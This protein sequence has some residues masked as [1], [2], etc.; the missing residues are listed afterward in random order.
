MPL[1]QT[2]AL[3]AIVSGLVIVRSSTT[4]SSYILNSDLPPAKLYGSNAIDVIF[5]S[6]AEKSYTILY[7]PLPKSVVFDIVT[8][9]FA[10]D[11]ILPS[12]V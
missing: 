5:P 11:A 1:S 4:S 2:V 7:V 10:A 6:T 8:Q 12:V 9:L 3:P